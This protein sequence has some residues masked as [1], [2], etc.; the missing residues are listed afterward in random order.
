VT[1]GQTDGIAE[2]STALAMRALQRAVKTHNENKS[3]E[4]A[5]NRHSAIVL[6]RTKK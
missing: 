6:L 5:L 3:T 1:D 4:N 2:A